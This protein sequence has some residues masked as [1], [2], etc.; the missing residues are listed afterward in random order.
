MNSNSSVELTERI[1]QKATSL[2]ATIAGIA[3]VESLKTSPSH[4]IYSKIGMDLKVQWQ[5]AR[6]A[7]KFSELA[8]PTDAVSAVVIGVVHKANEPEL[9]W[10]DGQ[11]GTPGNRILI[12]INRKLSEWIEHTLG[13]TTYKLPYMIE[14]GGIFLKDAAVMAGLGCIG[15]SN[16]IIN[17]IYGPRIRYRAL[18]MDR[19]AD[20]TGPIEFNPCQDCK[21]PCRK[22]CPIKAFQHPVYP[23]DV[24]GQHELPGINGTYDR[25]TCYV[26]ME[27]DVEDTVIEMQ[28]DEGKQNGIR[29]AIDKFEGGVLIKPAADTQS[30]SYVKYCRRCELA[31]PVGKQKS[32]QI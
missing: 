32:R 21:Q 5:H 11:G 6:D 29:Q 26:K 2:G 23:A 10:W 19:E 28:G 9:D 20:A 31:C 4:Q 8:W 7:D 3:S 27:K 22:A 12:Q 13:I 16:L 1:V 17:P 24:L 15:N 25:V 18:L 30:R 14:K